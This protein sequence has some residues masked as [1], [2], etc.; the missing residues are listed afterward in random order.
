MLICSMDGERWIICVVRVQGEEIACLSLKRG[1]VAF[2]PLSLVSWRE[3]SNSLIAWMIALL[4]SD[5]SGG[6]WG[7]KV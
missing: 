4:A 7:E 6:T 1:I 3:G 5:G 2:C